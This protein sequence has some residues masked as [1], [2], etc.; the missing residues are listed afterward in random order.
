MWSSLS[1][2][3]AAKHDD[4]NKMDLKKY[5]CQDVKWF[6]LPVLKKYYALLLLPV[7][8][9]QYAGMLTVVTRKRIIYFL[10]VYYM[11]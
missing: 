11:K 8:M 6:N 5:T 10:Q 9:T 3:I 4:N 1:Q 2:D 7:I